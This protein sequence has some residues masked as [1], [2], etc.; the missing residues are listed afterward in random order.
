MKNSQINQMT[1]SFCFDLK[2]RENELNYFKMK[3]KYGYS[4]TKEEK[5]IF[6]KNVTTTINNLLENNIIFPE[7]GNTCLIEIAEMSGKNII[8]LEKNTKKDILLQLDNQSMMKA[9][10][11]KLYKIISENETV[12]MAQLPGN[13]RK[14]LEKLLFKSPKL[15]LDKSYTFLDD[16]IFSGYTFLAAQEA[17]KS[18][19]HNN[20]VLFSKID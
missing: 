6:Q 17:I 16:S 3:N 1:Y 15:S 14:R 20:I 10:R 11:E 5:F 4:F 8:V 9:E 18:V 7:T 2:T 13:Q 12:K 19:K